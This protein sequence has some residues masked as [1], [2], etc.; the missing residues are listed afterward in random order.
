VHWCGHFLSR[1]QLP[2][3]SFAIVTRKSRREKELQR[4]SLS[5][6]ATSGWSALERMRCVKKRD[7]GPAVMFIT[8]G[9]HTKL[10]AWGEEDSGG[11]V[12]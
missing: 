7:L 3:I 5:E 12:L 11:N 6:R 8:A 1:A 9:P 2:R 10:C 4:E